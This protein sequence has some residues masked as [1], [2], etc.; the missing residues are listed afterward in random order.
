MRR[1][2]G[3]FATI[4]TGGRLGIRFGVLQFSEP[5]LLKAVLTCE[6]DHVA[7]ID[8]EVQ[9]IYGKTPS[10]S[11][12]QMAA[13]GVAAPAETPFEKVRKFVNDNRKNGFH[14]LRRRADRR[15]RRMAAKGAQVLGYVGEHDGWKEFWIPNPTFQ[16]QAGGGSAEN[17]LK[18][19]LHARGLIVVDRR[20]KGVSYVVKRTLPDGRRPNFVVL[21]Y[22]TPDGR[23]KC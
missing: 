19:E 9:K 23:K 14:N 15:P 21:R 1:L 10:A 6:R 22:T 16:Q 18:K 7:F 5:E 20:G 17:A 12:T 3:R 11:L 2:H 13:P 8:A 4:Y